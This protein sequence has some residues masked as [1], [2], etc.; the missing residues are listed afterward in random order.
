MKKIVIHSAIYLSFLAV[1]GGCDLT[2]DEIDGQSGTQEGDPVVVDFPI[3]YIQRPVPVGLAD[4]NDVQVSIL[5][6]NVLEPSESQAG[7]VLV[8]KDRAAV[9]AP[10]RTITEGVFPQVTNGDGELEEPLY[11]V[12][13]LSANAEG[14]KLVFS[15]RAPLNENL[16]NDDPDQPSWNIWEYEIATDTL[17]R[18]IDSNIEA[19]KG[20]DRFPVYL[21]DDSII[22]SSTRQKNSKELLLNLN[23]SGYTYVTE[24][25]DES[26]A[27][28]LHR[29]DEDREEI[30]QISYGKGH[31]IYPTI[32]DDGR[33]LFLRGDDTSNANRDR[34]S[35]YTINP[36]GT[37]LNLHYGFHSASSSNA[38]DQGAL[39]KPQEMP[40]GEILVAFK[41]RETEIFGGDILS[42]D[43]AN[44]IDDT[45]PTSDNIGGTGPAERS[46]SVGEVILEEQ[47]PHGYFYSAYPMFDGTGRL[48]VSW[49]PCLVQ[50]YRLNIYVERIDTDV[51][52][53]NDNVVG[54]DTTYQLINVDGELVD[55]DGNRLA[56][57]ADPV[58]VPFEDIT[59]LPCTSDTFENDVISPS[60]PQFGIWVY[61]TSSE[62]QDPVVLANEI[63]TMYTEAIVVEPKTSPTFIPD[64]GSADEFTASLVEERVGVIHIRSI[65][66]IDGVDSVGIANMADPVITA[67]DARP[68]RFVRFLSQANMPHE[69]DLEIDE[70]LIEGRNNNPSR[71]IIGYAQ[72]HPDGSVMAK[73][74]ADTAFA[75]EFVDAN[76]RR[77]T[78]NFNRPHRN[79]LNVRPGE[80]R[81]CNGCHAANSTTPHGRFDAE[82]DSANPGAL[83]PA[84][85]PNT[86]LTDR[87]GTPYPPPEVG[88]TMAEFYVRTKLQDSEEPDPLTLSLDLVFEDEW[89]DP[90]IGGTTVGTP[91]NI[92]F[93]NPEALLPENLLTLAP[94]FLAACLTEWEYRCRTVIDYPDHIQPIFEVART[95]TDDMDQVIDITCMNCH[96]PTD[97][98]GLAQI[99]APDI[100]GLQLDFTNIVSPLDDDM[101]LLRGY[102]EL[103]AAGDPVLE[104]D[105]N[106]NIVVRQIPL[107]VN[108]Q[109]QFQMEPIT[110]IDGNPTFE[111]LDL[112]GTTL[113]L[114]S[115]AEVLDP[116]LTPVLDPATNTPVACTRIT[117]MTDEDTGEQLF[118][119]LNGNGNFDRGESCLTGQQQP[120]LVPDEQ[121]RYL[122]ANG[123]NANQNQRFFDA[124]AEGGAH[125]GYLTPAEIK[126]F[127]EWLDVGGQ[128][129][130]DLFKAV[131][132]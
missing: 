34:L 86:S 117:C 107:V 33:V 76:G 2:D 18:V 98:D 122:S 104:I 12:R 84:H 101:I 70:D 99:A 129:Y 13:D 109:T 35:L 132:D 25:D 79:W 41:P 74:P 42:I 45:Q 95:T 40:N 36:D 126:L 108:G 69:D 73:V 58:V 118:N 116:D 23:G 115:G 17:T 52:D 24:S 66:D 114:A 37:N 94:V 93:G 39:I 88:E 29:I 21:P 15:M 27:F 43:T 119:D 7:A 49:M 1:I 64:A 11:D 78:G 22:F 63:G 96:S 31:D 89:T 82:A 125:E 65:Y 83:A 60:E 6:E 113:C 100:N 46:I 130:N 91:I 81:T 16:D 128:Y 54:V 53:N 56:A 97:P 48:L 51:L 77:V 92:A 50:G 87:F 9:S 55:E 106:D 103:F 14:T 124:F 85:F 26:R 30:I 5:P 38:D 120:I 19:E 47:S 110:D 10:S 121:N 59:S 68:I 4:D 123:A 61:D 102:D 71:S 111:F 90:A 44:Y 72:V 105:D 131:E 67:T 112:S 75:M 20:H 57:G 28:T 62:T 3:A 80:V 127:S 8:L 32:M